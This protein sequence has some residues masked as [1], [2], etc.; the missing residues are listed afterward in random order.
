MRSYNKDL[1]FKCDDRTYEIKCLKKLSDILTELNLVHWLD[2]G[3][4]LGAV[5]ENDIIN[6]DV[7]L[8]IG[9]IL[10]ESD[11]WYGQNQ[12]DLLSHLQ[13]EFFIKYFMTDKFVSLV[14]RYNI[15]EFKM[16]HIDLYFWKN[17]EK[18]VVSDLL[19]NM[20]FRKFFV[21]ELDIFI[22]NKESFFIPRHTTD[23]LKM[24]YGLDWKIP[25]KDFSVEF[26][27]VPNKSEYVCYTS[28]VGDLFHEG[29]I[30]LLK[31]CKF[32]FDKVIVGVHND[33]QVM[34]YKEK[35]HDSYKTR[36]ENIKNSEYV[37]EI[38]ENAPPITTD[39]LVNEINAD[40][41]VAGREGEEKIKKMYPI[42]PDKLHLIK[43]TEG[44]SSS[45]LRKKLRSV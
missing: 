19:P 25:K 15:N 24:R 6:W 31:R 36:L 27:I 35:P 44:I 1:Y 23:F 11:S 14:P 2:F 17:K 41:V 40:F 39:E 45:M 33:E 22:L 13:S 34:S 37:D 30:N 32:L 43:R 38:Y 26:N 16:R 29:H 21:D 10:D 9:C 18:F 20:N 7:D 3:T 5:R 4:L 42:N 28:M 8:D 12:I